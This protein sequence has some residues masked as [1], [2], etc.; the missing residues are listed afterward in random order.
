MTYIDLKGAH[1]LNIS[2]LVLLLEA[3]TTVRV[4]FP[5]APTNIP[6]SRCTRFSSLGSWKGMDMTARDVFFVMPGSGKFSFSSSRTQ[7]FYPPRMSRVSVR[8]QATLLAPFGGVE[9]P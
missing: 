3:F 5:H 8:A 2:P 7:T 1:T 9:N 4:V 6:V